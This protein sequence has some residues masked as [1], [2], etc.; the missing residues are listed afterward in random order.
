MSTIDLAFENPFFHNPEAEKPEQGNA[1]GEYKA[2]SVRNTLDNAYVPAPIL[3]ARKNQDA[4]IRERFEGK[5]LTIADIGC[6][7]GYHGEIFGPDARIYHGFEIS[8]EMAQASRERWKNIDGAQVFEGDARST[9]LQT[10]AYDIAW[11]LY[12]TSG[13]FRQEF[14]SLSSYDDAYLDE[15]PAFIGIVCRFYEALK[16]G[17][18]LFLTVY[19]DVPKTEATQREF[20][21][22]TGQTVV[23][24]LGSRFVATKEDFWSVRWTKESMLS[25]LRACGIEPKQVV[26]NDLNEIAWL[27]EV[28]K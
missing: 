5:P 28:T 8:S 9:L 16:S 21:E 22:K 12:F 20:Y 26:F 19:K 7:D 24:P 1:L 14:A 11:S 25:N 13:N 18:K 3:D 23:T 2:E 10:N 17:G 4:L 27:V 15:N 6:G